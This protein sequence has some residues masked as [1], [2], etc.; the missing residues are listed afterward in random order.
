MFR[1]TG[2]ESDAIVARLDQADDLYVDRVSQIRMPQ[3]SR[4]RVAQIGDAAAA[5]SLLAGEGSSLAMTQAHILAGEV[6]R[7][8]NRAPDALRAYESRLK[9]VLVKK[10]DSAR[11]CAGYFVPKTWLGLI[12][13]DA[14]S[15]LASVP[16]LA[17]SMFGR[18]F[19]DHIALP[20]RAG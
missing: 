4:G 12:A 8:P 18:T 14:I 11:N 16:C 2:S 17:N 1:D 10:Q 3:W 20:D 15:N 6:A 19:R 13:S 9:G 7:S 5:P